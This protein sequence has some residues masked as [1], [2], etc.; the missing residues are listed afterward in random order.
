MDDKI[1]NGGRKIYS[2]FGGGEK[3]NGKSSSHFFVGNRVGRKMGCAFAISV[4]HI[5]GFVRKSVI[6]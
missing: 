2:F 5:V 3:W 4:G 6:I 1:F